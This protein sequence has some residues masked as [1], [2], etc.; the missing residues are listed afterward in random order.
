MELK[1]AVLQR[2]SI[3]GYKKCPVSRETLTE[4]IAVSLRAPSAM[5]IQPWE[6]TI[7]AGEPLEELR[8]ANTEMLRSGQMPAS[9]FGPPQPFAGVHKM[10]QRDLGFEL[11]ALLGIARDDQAR[12]I[13][14]AMQGF[15]FFDAPAAIILSADENLDARLAASDIGGL[16]QTF[17]LVALEYGLGTC[18]NSQGIMYPEA[19]RK[20]TGIPASKKIYLCIAVGYPDADHPANKLIS[21][22][23]S[24]ETVVNWVGF[25]T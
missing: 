9:D 14:W 20:V 22:R 3:R 2:R 13:E 4:I 1:D 6:I 18:I 12:R 24:I 5:N 21:K 25:D 19:V 7:V 16:I 23:E 11:Y 17:C 15:R 8:K 10:R